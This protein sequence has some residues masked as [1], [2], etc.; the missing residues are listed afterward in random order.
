[1]PYILNKTNGVVLTTIDDASLDLTTNLTFVGRN[2]SGYGEIFNENFLKLL[3]NFSNTTAPSKPVQGQ[4][5]FD[6][7][8]DN[9]K[10]NFCY[11]GKSFKSLATMQV[12]TDAPS[13]PSEGDLWWDSNDNQLK[14]F[15]GSTYLI[16]GPQT[17]SAARSSWAFDEEADANDLTEVQNPIIKG[18]IGSDV[19]L[20]IAKLSSSVTDNGTRLVPKG[21][22]NL[23]N[24]FSKGVRKGITLAGADANGSTKA[25]GYYFWGTAAEALV[26][27]TATT[28]T[29]SAKNTGTTAHY[30]TFV[31]TSTGNVALLSD[32]GLSYN[33]T[34]NVLTTTAS[35]ARYG[36][37]AEK[38]LADKEYPPGT[39]VAV[40]GTAEITACDEGDRAIG[41][42]S[43][44][45]GYMMNSELANGTYVALK[46][47][48][49][50]LVEGPV[51]KSDRLVAGKDGRARSAPFGH[52][53]VFA[54]A[55]S[56]T[57]NGG[58]IE[59]IVL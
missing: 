19:V 43:E 46:G 41:V 7:T 30:L 10:L 32:T 44:K 58:T 17:S 5:W 54:V 29:V 57:D 20:T 2:Y 8:P 13:S 35:A 11:D 24:D 36:D 31:S 4:L 47:R 40:G 59:A 53:D 39:V 6:S 45:P 26:A 1:M 15:D 16:V 14:A 9:R 52:L 33:P 12:Q 25:A 55:L 49:P 42:V 18:K 28:V 50:V 48:V 56:S 38:Y 22:S 51:R 37:L 3:E 34:D 27:N 21:T 23:N